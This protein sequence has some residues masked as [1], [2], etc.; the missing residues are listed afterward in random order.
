MYYRI[1][2]QIIIIA[3]VVLFFA[4]VGSGIYF[5]FLKPA[6]SCFDGIRNQDEEEIDC[7]GAICQSCEFKTISNIEVFWAQAIPA[8]DNK[9]DLAAEIR[10]PN[11]NYGVAELA[12]GFEIKN[13]SGQV[14][15]K[16]EGSTFILP[17]SAKYIIENNFQTNQPVGSVD[18][19]VGKK[20]DLEWRKLNDYQ[21]IELFILDKKFDILNQENFWGRASGTVKNETD[22]GFEKVNVN[23]IVFDKELRPIGA[24][25]TTMNSLSAG[26]YRAFSVGWPKAFL[27]EFGTIEMQTETNLFSDDNYMRVYGES[28]EP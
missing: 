27:G 1:R 6:P 10:N 8:D 25:Q 4:L 22:F 28:K 20:E 21:A 12:Y 16:K 7:G 2:K 24:A 26:E 5:W 14:I 23:I 19:T 13:V 11:P 18:L 17:G 3:V 15:G 9:I